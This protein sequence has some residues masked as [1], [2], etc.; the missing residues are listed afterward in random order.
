MWGQFHL[1]DPTLNF[2]GCDGILHYF[3]RRILN[4]EKPH[5]WLLQT[6]GNF[7][8]LIETF[9]FLRRDLSFLA[10]NFASKSLLFNTAEAL[11]LFL[12]DIQVVMVH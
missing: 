1:S 4:S 6:Q 7:L 2:P 5:F 9:F 8:I 11:L 10:R 3:H 12:G